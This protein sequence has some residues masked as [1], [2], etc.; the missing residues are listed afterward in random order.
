[1]DDIELSGVQSALQAADREQIFTSVEYGSNNL[2]SAKYRAVEEQCDAQA[3]HDGFDRI[4]LSQLDL[5][6]RN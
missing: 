3:P 2:L 5:Q 4:K 6:I 1:M